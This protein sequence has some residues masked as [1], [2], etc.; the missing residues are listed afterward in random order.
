MAAVSRRVIFEEFSRRDLFD[1]A[2]VL[3]SRSLDTFR[4][5]AG[6]LFRL[7]EWARSPVLM[8]TAIYLGG[9]KV[10]TAVSRHLLNIEIAV[11]SVSL[12]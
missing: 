5:L 6:K 2:R 8:L 4:V 10:L 12:G 7:A 3:L 1:G 11:A 9:N